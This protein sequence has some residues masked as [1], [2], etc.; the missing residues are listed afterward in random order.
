MGYLI[1]VTVLL[2][3]HAVRGREVPGHHWQVAKVGLVED[4]ALKGLLVQSLVSCSHA[5]RILAA[6]PNA[7]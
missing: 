5:L 6:F 7:N 1:V 3:P 4:I 2:G